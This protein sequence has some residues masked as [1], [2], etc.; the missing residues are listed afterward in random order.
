M[1]VN[2]EM[3][4]GDDARDF[5]DDALDLVGKR[6][7]VGVAKHDP[8]RAR[9]IGGAR[10]VERVGGIGLVAVEEMLA[11]DHRLAPGGERRLHAVFDAGEVFLQRA[12][13]RDVD[14]IVPGLGDEHDGVGVGGEQRGEAG[15]V[16]GRAAGALGHAEGA[17]PRALRRL[18][19]EEPRVERIGAGI[20]AL[21]IVDAEPIEQRRDLQL[22][23]EREVDAG[24]QRA[25]AQRRVEEVEAFAGH[26]VGPFSGASAA[27]ASARGAARRLVMVV[28]AS[29][30]S[31]S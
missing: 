3:V 16:G 17:E 23:F 19:L 29:H 7:A 27:G 26:G 2:A 14:V 8:A 4:A 28:F 5:G 12:A 31:S 1:R 13:E 21:D 30:W 22:V 9:P 25:V 15:I 18:A 10:A 20:A 6:A 11:V 24:G